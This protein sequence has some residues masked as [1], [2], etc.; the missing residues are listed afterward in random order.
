MISFKES[1]NWEAPQEEYSCD[2]VEHK[3]RQLSEDLS[4]L[5]DHMK[6]TYNISD[7][8]FENMRKGFH[9]NTKLEYIEPIHFFDEERD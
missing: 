7:E 2:Y 1:E 3:E 8:V 4:T 6:K 5:C 9:I